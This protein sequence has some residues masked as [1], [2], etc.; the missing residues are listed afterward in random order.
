MVDGITVRDFDIPLADGT[1]DWWAFVDVSPF[2][3]QTATLTVDSLS[4]GSSGLSSIVQS[5][6]I[7]GAT[8]L[9]HETLRP[10][11]H[12]SSRRGWL[13]DA[14]GMVF[15][16]G[17]YHLYYQNDPYTWSGNHKHWG[18]AA[19]SDM[20]HWHELPEAIYPHTYH[21]DVWSGSAV[22]DWANT[23]GF[24]TGTNDV[25][26]AAFTSTGRGECIAY[27]NDGGL[28]FTDYTNNP[29]VVHTGRDPHLLWY[30]PSNYWVMAVYDANGGD[31]IAF[32]SSP[33]LRQWTYR[34]RISGFFECPDLYQ[35]PVDGQTNN[36]KWVLSDASSGYMIGQFNGAVFTPETAKLPGNSGSVFY[37]AQT[38][39]EMPP[40]DSRCVR[41]GWA[42]ISMPNMPFNQTLFFPTELTLRTLSAGV[43]LCSEPIAEITNA[44]ANTYSWTNLTLNPGSN[45]LSGIRGE[46]FDLRAEFTPGSAQAI[47]F[48]LCGVPV[49]YFPAAQQITCKGITKSL[50]PVN[51]TVKIQVIT[52]CQSVEIFGNSGQLY[53]PI[54]STSYSP[55]NNLLS[56]TNQ[57]ASTIFKTLTVNKL[58]S[59][60]SSAGN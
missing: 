48:V 47:T 13:N 52:D 29:V 35:M 49:T 51:G 11:I 22:V 56:L 19:S 7:V 42:V 39:T 23:S 16:N 54:G 40:G 50:P 44:V 30:A 6:G 2:Q 8:N 1:P 33:N 20:V 26:V 5:N 21:D 25:I 41:I 58:K 36:M 18:H 53:M 15:Y 12:F 10:Q 55:T 43:R 4:P 27:S 46:I 45:P 14:N 28:S 37:A 32:Y 59:I 17:E 34:S 9:Y 57:G 3:G 31:G 24:K 60:W 38:F